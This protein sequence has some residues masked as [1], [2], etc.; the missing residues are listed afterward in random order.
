MG[1]GMFIS[2][3]ILEISDPLVPNQI[4]GPV[5]I[6]GFLLIS[7]EMPSVPSGTVS[8]PIRVRSM[9]LPYILD[10]FWKSG[11]TRFPG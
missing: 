11:A 7:G 1:T 2:V 5:Q 9:P 3:R 10:Y 8:V 4:P 6:Y